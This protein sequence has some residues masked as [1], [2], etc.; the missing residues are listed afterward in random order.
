MSNTL[1]VHNPAELELIQSISRHL[2]EPEWAHIYRKEAWYRFLQAP[3]PSRTHEHWRRTDISHLNLQNIIPALPVEHRAAPEWLESL[4]AGGAKR[5]GGTLAF[6]DGTLVHE[7][8]TESLR[9][10]G[11]IFTSWSQAIQ[12]HPD[13]VRRAIEGVDYDPADEKFTAMA[14]AYAT[15][16]AVLIV[17][18]GVEVTLPLQA[19]FAAEATNAVFP[20]TLVVL[21]EDSRVTLLDGMLSPDLPG[22]AF[23][24]GVADLVLG[25]GS[26]LT[27]V[28][29][30][31]WGQGMEYFHHQRAVLGRDSHLTTITV[32]LGASL[33]KVTIESV[34]CSPGAVS[35]MLGV[36][37]G[38][39]KQ[40]FDHHTVQMH[41][42]GNTTSDLLFKVAL[43]EQAYS[44]YSGLIRIEPGAQKANAYQRNENLVLS[45]TAHAETLP[46]LEIEANDVRCTHGATVAPVDVEQMFYLM[47]RGLAPRDAKRLIVE[48]FLQPVLDR[49][50]AKS[51]REMVSAKVDEKIARRRF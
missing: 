35:D 21:E 39:S 29:F 36:V 5:V 40:H 20:H 7:H 34:L 8:L 27:Y 4:M 48:G 37:F 31:Q 15:G 41:T 9:K 49:I 14:R 23:G 43:D 50:S 33:S 44:A 24:S 51:L 1:T 6:V 17:P 28:L 45:S 13:P 26:E 3:T 22:R 2:A 16:G 25:S 12:Q 30:Q 32:A 11:V 10:R 19:F 18:R 47:S 38:D 46:N 42:V